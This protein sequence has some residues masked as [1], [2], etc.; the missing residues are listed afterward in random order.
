MG[1]AK[2]DKKFINEILDNIGEI[3]EEVN[4]EVSFIIDIRN[5][6]PRDLDI[7]RYDN[8][9]NIINHLQNF[10]SSVK[11]ACSNLK[12]QFEAI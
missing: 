10:E 4:Y 1:K 7:I 11:K 2:V 6:K 12:K 3:M 9:T 5:S 8:Y